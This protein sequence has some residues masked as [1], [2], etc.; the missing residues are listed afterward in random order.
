MI[1]TQI[2]VYIV[3]SS[4]T[5]MFVQVDRDILIICNGRGNFFHEIMQVPTIDRLVT[6]SLQEVTSFG[7]YSYAPR[8]S[9]LCIFGQVP[10]IQCTLES[11]VASNSSNSVSRSQFLQSNVLLWL[12]FV[13]PSP[14]FLNIMYQFSFFC[15]ISSPI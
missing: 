4:P 14:N 8:S 6:S 13:F 5:K 15:H 2:D 11:K 12:L 10:S 7:V 1:L 9:N 3:V